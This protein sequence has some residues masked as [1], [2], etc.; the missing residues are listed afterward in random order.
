MKIKH[1]LAAAAALAFLF[2][3][4]VQ[5]FA[6]PPGQVSYQGTLRKNGVL[7]S[8]AAAM[9][10]RVTNADGSVVYW[11]SGSTDV[12]VSTGLFRYGL[13]SPDE[14]G[15]AAI[16]WKEINPYVQMNLDGG[17]LPR[18]PLYTSVYSLHAKT[19]ESSTGTFTI[20]G[21]D[22]RLTAASGSKGIYF[23][24]GTAQYSA[25][26]WAVTG[27]YTSFAGGAGVG[28]LT[29]ATRLDVQGTLADPNLQF[30]R[31]EN[32]IVKATMTKSGILYADGSRL[33][34]LP[35]GADNMGNHTA[36]TALL[37]ANLPIN[38]VGAITANGQITTYSSATVAAALGLGVPRVRLASSVELSS[39]SAGGLYIS[40]NVTLAAGGKYFGNGSMLSGVND[41]LGNHIATQTLNMAGYDILSVSTM[42]VNRALRFNSNVE[43]SSA[44]G[45]YSGVYISTNMNL[46]AGARYY[47]DGSALTGIIGDRNVNLNTFNLVNVA[48]ITAHAASSVAVVGVLDVSGSGYT[49]IWRNAAGVDVASMTDAGILYADGSQL[50]NLVGGGGGGGDL[51][52]I[53][54][55]NG[56]AGAGSI[57]NLSSMAVGRVTGEAPLDVQSAVGNTFSQFWRDSSGV[58]KATMTSDGSLN[59]FGAIVN[60]AQLTNATVISNLAVGD[61]SSINT[62]MVVNAAGSFFGA[63]VSDMNV[64][65]SGVSL[66][67]PPG[68]MTAEEKV[69]GGIFAGILAGG[70]PTAYDFPNLIG[71]MGSAVASVLPAATVTNTYGLYSQNYLFGP[72]TITNNYGVFV[73]T[74]SASLGVI[75][76]N[77]G[78]Y[79]RDNS[80]VVGGTASYNIYSEGLT[81]RNYFE[82]SVETGGG[83]K[84]NTTTATPTCDATN[85]G[86][87]WLEQGA[88]GFK[89]GVF[90]CAKDSGDAYAWR[91]LY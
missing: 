50:R 82:G 14:A 36:T 1:G 68:D 10:F 6:A 17:W 9:E 88:S 54:A 64:A 85:R 23:Q 7:F 44:S 91:T 19:A 83:V 86:M 60:T 13:G 15:F 65:V 75:T 89:D 30:W 66:A 59:S 90:V 46:A 51:S 43:I 73:A 57:I 5:T 80:L 61:Q 4:G 28:T 67:I 52:T 26:G 11:T 42:T 35:A 76:N 49:Q 18:E 3:T 72:G 25:P 63:A 8:G 32:G 53:L 12:V 20:N 16:V 39:Y 74:P 84:L 87:L 56:N 21:G 71:V 40:S 81:A 37:M 22:L 27:S 33:S 62:S 55:A 38:N 24:D 78:I 79:V 29:P 48:S 31:D 34:N 70:A 45:A 77:Y 58:I 69:I 41:S 47:G 2:I